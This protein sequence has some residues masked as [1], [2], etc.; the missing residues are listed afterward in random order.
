MQFTLKISYAS[1]CRISSS[2]QGLALW[3]ITHLQRMHPTLHRP[4]YVP[5]A[6]FLFSALDEIGKARSNVGR[7][8]PENLAG[9]GFVRGGCGTANNLCLSALEL[10][11]GAHLQQP[12]A[13]VAHRHHQGFYESRRHYNCRNR[14]SGQHFLD[15]TMQCERWL[16]PAN[17]NSTLAFVGPN[18]LI[19]AELSRLRSRVD[20]ILIM[21]KLLC[22]KNDFYIKN[23]THVSPIYYG[24]PERGS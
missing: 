16:A 13:L 18:L 7:K 6:C 24:I 14:G 3:V 11:A 23:E 21:K 15:Y 12:L 22:T 17:F 8:R 1:H 2:F 9:R 4:G 10:R 20:E 5:W 19:F